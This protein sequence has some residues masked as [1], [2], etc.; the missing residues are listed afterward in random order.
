MLEGLKRA[1]YSV[2]AMPILH[3]GIQT[4]VLHLVANLSTIRGKKIMLAVIWWMS[5]WTKNQNRYTA[6]DP[7]LILE[8]LRPASQ[9]FTSEDMIK[10]EGW[11]GLPH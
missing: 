2:M 6:E 1:D 3:Q 7:V 9:P 8:I 11:Y 4:R 10:V 5:S